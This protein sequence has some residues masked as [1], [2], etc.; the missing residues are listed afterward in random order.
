MAKVTRIELTPDDP[1]FRSGSQI[2]VPASR[3][4]TKNSQQNTKQALPSFQKQINKETREQMSS[5]PTGDEPEDS[6]S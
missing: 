3:P 1:I 2:F 4:S 5:S 6:K